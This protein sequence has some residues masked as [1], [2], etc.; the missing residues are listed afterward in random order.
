MQTLSSHN[1]KTHISS[2]W[3]KSSPSKKYFTSD[4]V[5]DAYQTGK[6]EGLDLT[7]KLIKDKLSTNIELSGK[8]TFE[9][10]DKMKEQGLN[11][12]NAYLRINSWSDFDIL[13]LLPEEELLNDSIYSFYSFLAEFQEAKSNELF[14]FVV[15]FLAKKDGLNEG[16]L[17]SDGFYFS[18]DL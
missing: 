10:I 18:L 2:N 13:I 9:I 16:K 11:P 12:T 14:E 15:S 4:Q 17:Y 1:Q 8:Y 5:I 6:K 3:V 7:D